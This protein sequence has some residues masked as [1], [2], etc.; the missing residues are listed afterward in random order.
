MTEQPALHRCLV[1]V[2]DHAVNDVARRPPTFQSSRRSKRCSPHPH[3]LPDDGQPARRI[4]TVL[5]FAPTTP[6]SLPPA[7][8]LAEKVLVSSAWMDSDKCRPNPG[9]QGAD[10]GH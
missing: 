10:L 6:L 7:S 9:R 1:L 4:F 3:R 8:V 2:A 5:A